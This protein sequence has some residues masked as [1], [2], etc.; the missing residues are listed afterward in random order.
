MAEGLIRAR[1]E[2]GGWDMRVT[3]AGTWAVSGLPPTDEAQAAMAERG[4]DITNVRSLEV[5][6]DLVASAHL[7]LVMT[8]DHREGLLVDFPDAQERTLLFS[9]LVG[10]TWDVED[11]IGGTLDDYRSTAHTLDRLIESGWALIAGRVPDQARRVRP[12]GSEPA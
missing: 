8:R 9:E 1:V 12:E 2:S 6:A 4:I 11:P 7:I 5:D 10:A 3:S